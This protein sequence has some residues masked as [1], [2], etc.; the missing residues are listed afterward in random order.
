MR[1]T[2]DNVSKQSTETAT[3]EPKEI[4]I[5]PVIAVHNKNIPTKSMVPDPEWFDGNRTKFEDWWREIQ[6]FLKSNRVVAADDKIT[7]VLA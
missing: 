2:E 6:L 7:A 3:S 4:L 1:I 5:A